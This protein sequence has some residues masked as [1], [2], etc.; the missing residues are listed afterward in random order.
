MDQAPHCYVFAGGGSGG[1]LFPGIAVAQQLRQMDPQAM[2]IFC[3]TEKHI[4][5]IIM[6]GRQWDWFPQPV[7]PLPSRPWKWWAFYQ[8][9]R[10]SLK[11]CR[12]LIETE[13]A[14]C[15]LGL[16]GYASGP[17]LE[18]AQEKGVPAA[19]LN[20]DAVPGK[21]NR[22][23]AARCER[24]FTAFASSTGSFGVHREKC[25]VIGC[26]VRSEI[27]EWQRSRA[28]W[29][30]E[31]DADRPTLL[32][33]G[34]SLGGRNVNEAAQQALLE[35]YESRQLGQWQIVH[36]T[37]KGSHREIMATYDQAGLKVTTLEFSQEMAMVLAAADLAVCRAG[38]S[39]VAELSLRG[40]PM[41][42]LPYP[43]HR[44]QHQW[45]NAAEYERVGAAVIVR[46]EK[47]ATATGHALK[48]ALTELFFDKE[49]R[50]AM[51]QAAQQT[52][53]ASAA[54]EIA[55]ELV[56]MAQRYRRER[57]ECNL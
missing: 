36:I 30:L 11:V 14:D 39:S 54:A 34:G 18:V 8:A 1:H 26:P 15:V 9:W 56:N 57:P 42:L 22:W 41:I 44:D 33:M 23:G 5:D 40:I 49:K 35:L 38:A 31:L 24:I 17:A 19:L 2:V 37:G 3:T 6:D 32:I 27:G 21:A 4:D 25:R 29:S 52:A 16:G 48:T 20:P 10:G 50:Q 45:K 47:D 46:D 28:V 51:G 55:A 43:Y 13:R 12:E 53:R 7:L